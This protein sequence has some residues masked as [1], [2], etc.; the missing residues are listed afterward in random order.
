MAVTISKNK[1]FETLSS[2]GLGTPTLN[3]KK[4]E[5]EKLRLSRFTLIQMMEVGV[6]L[7]MMLGGGCG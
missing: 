1:K 2:S 7:E 3:S 6:L 5:R 4:P